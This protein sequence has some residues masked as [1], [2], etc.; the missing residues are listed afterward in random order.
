MG[1][2]K[3][4][5]DFSIESHLN[6]PPKVL[7]KAI[8]LL[9]SEQDFGEG[10]MPHYIHQVALKAEKLR[11]LRQ[12]RFPG[13]D[14]DQL[15]SSTYRHSSEVDCSACD[16]AQVE[17]RLSRDSGDPIVHYGLIASG[18]AVLRS[19]KRRDELR[20][21]WG[22]LC[23]EMEATGLMDN[24][25]CV[26]ITEICDYS[27]DH[28]NKIW[29]P[30]SAVVAAAYAKDLL[31]VV[32]P[33]E[34]ETMEAITKT[35]EKL[36]K[37]FA[38]TGEAVKRI[39]SK[40][41]S[42]EDIE[43]LEWLTPFLAEIFSLQSTTKAK[44]FATARHIQDI[45]NEFD[46]SILLEIRAKEDDVRQYLEER[47]L[48]LPSFVFKRPELQE[49]ILDQ[50]ANAADGM[51]LLAKLHLDSLQH[52]PTPKVIFQALD[53]FPKGNEGLN[54]TY[55]ETMRRIRNQGLEFQQ[56][57][58][59]ALSWITCA[60]RQLSI[61]EL[62]TAL[63]VEKDSSEMDEDNIPEIEDIVSACAGLVT[64][65]KNSNIVRLL[66]TPLSLSARNGHEAIV[67]LLLEI[68]ADPESRNVDGQ[69]A[70]MHAARNGHEAIVRL[71]LMHEADL[72]SKD[73]S[74]WT[75]VMHVAL[76]GNE[77]I[78]E[79][80][81]EMGPNIESKDVNGRTAL[82]HAAMHDRE[83][84]V[85]LLV[86]NGADLESVD[87]NGSTI[88]MHTAM[89]SHEATVNMLLE[90]GANLESV[91]N[92]GWTALIYAAMYGHEATVKLLVD[93]GADL[94]PKDKNTR[95]VSEKENHRWRIS[96]RGS[97]TIYDAPAQIPGR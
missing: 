87:K 47:L 95:S 53:N 94:K 88:L 72:D 81:L 11:G 42:K 26:V 27:D 5:T 89:S 19:A 44:L 32:Q 64:V 34:V 63:A 22:V 54:E 50:I 33:Q 17:N 57:A 45:R 70:L 83:A 46:G 71:L 35:L 28:K 36:S 60:M 52:K 82:I 75:V 77:T 91:D 48:G 73:E 96:R 56:L 14:K 85:K 12:Y 3:N 15:F 41:T 79:M 2:W 16:P 49:R 86:H 74:G 76:S 9:Q 80:L 78:V 69:T 4:D 29:Q 10:H 43:I 23:F 66:E 67:E 68:G 21:A 25:L 55:G 51:F 31:R 30:Y 39:E 58:L 92:N 65:D 24:F 59:R 93:N 20:D 18:D 40:I 90:N 62:Q 6:K 37:D 1:K 38:T 8:E 13:R 97:W 7:S 84:T 61:F